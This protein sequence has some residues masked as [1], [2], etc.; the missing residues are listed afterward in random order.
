MSESN[1]N[2]LKLLLYDKSYTCPLCEQAFTA[3]AIRVGKNQLLSVDDDLYAHYSC[4]NPLLYDV[5]SCPYCNYS[6]IVKNFEKLLP[7]QRTWL[8]DTLVSIFTHPTSYSEYTTTEEAIH[9]HKLALL[10]AINKKTKLGEQSYLALHIAWLY[11]DLGDIENEQLFLQK[12]FNGFSE[13]LETEPT[14]IQGIDEYTLM[15]MLAAIAF[16]LN[17]IEATKQYLSVL[18]TTPG[19]SSRIKDRVIDLKEKLKNI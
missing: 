11:R 7:K 9:K 10:M 13:A 19:I 18:L 1:T 15:Y 5:I 3:K 17:N 14:P 16:K 12:A 8:Q 6:A 2:D 4:V